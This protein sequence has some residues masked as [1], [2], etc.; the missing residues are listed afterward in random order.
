MDVTIIVFVTKERSIMANTVSRSWFA[1]LPHPEKYY[2][3]SP[4]E[5]V[6]EMKKYEL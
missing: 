1:V 5:I 4:E 6:E 2:Q 3:G